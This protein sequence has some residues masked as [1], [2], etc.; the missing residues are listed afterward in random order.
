MEFYIDLVPGT[1]PVFIALYRM[2][3]V[4]L[5]ELKSNLEEL[6]EKHFI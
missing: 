1:T 4:E 2:S 6:L 3:S 5:K